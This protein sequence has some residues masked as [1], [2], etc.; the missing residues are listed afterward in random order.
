M[1]F[2]SL[3]TGQCRI[4]EQKKTAYLYK[5]L[6]QYYCSIAHHKIIISLLALQVCIFLF[7][8]GGCVSSMAKDFSGREVKIGRDIE[9]DVLRFKD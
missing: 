2:L 5:I 9:S 7:L 1:K 4:Y 3:E 6:T 8:F